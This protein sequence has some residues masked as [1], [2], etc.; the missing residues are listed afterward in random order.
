MPSFPGGRKTIASTIVARGP[1]LL[2]P[3]S[4]LNPVSIISGIVTVIPSPEDEL[5]LELDE[6]DELELVG[7]PCELLDEEEGIE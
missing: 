1:V 5:L 7:P 3:V 6:L 4:G 2:P